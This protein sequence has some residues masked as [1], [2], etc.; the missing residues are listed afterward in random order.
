MEDKAPHSLCHTVAIARRDDKVRR[1]L[2][3]LACVPHRHTDGH[4]LEH[5]D[6]IFCVADGHCLGRS[7]AEMREKPED[8][9]SLVDT[10]RKDLTLPWATLKYICARSCSTCM[11]GYNPQKFEP[12]VLLGLPSGSEQLSPARLVRNAPTTWSIGAHTE[13]SSGFVKITNLI[14]SHIGYRCP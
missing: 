6:V 4:N 5:F 8:T 7:G 12:G 3:G 14:R 9:G 11:L 13:G 1:R 10:G 2:C